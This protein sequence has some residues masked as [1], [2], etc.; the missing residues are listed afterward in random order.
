MGRRNQPTDPKAAWSCFLTNA[1]VV[2]GLGTLLLGRW[3]GGIQLAMA[4]GGV[5]MSGYS[6]FAMMRPLLGEES[7][8]V[9]SLDWR[10]LAASLAL[11]LAGW[12][13][14]MADGWMLWRQ[15]LAKASA[16]PP[17]LEKKVQENE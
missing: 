6:V 17:V 4:V 12:I 16:V 10:P 7:A 1:L 9:F 15:A 3:R 2:P 8:P 5:M 14:A 13:W 11:F